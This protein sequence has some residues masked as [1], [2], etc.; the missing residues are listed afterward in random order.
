VTL[1]LVSF[2]T[3][4]FATVKAFENLSWL[5]L[6]VAAAAVFLTAAST[7][8]SSRKKATAKA[9]LTMQ[10]LE[11][12]RARMAYSIRESALPDAVAEQLFD[13]RAWTEIALPESN[14]ARRIGELEEVKLATVS[15]LG[16]AAA[17][18]E[19]KKLN[20]DE[21]DRILERRRAV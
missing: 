18:S 20:R 8:R 6:A 15:T 7:L 19:A 12:Q 11:A 10:E 4:V 2:A 3:A 16:S 1:L 17:E 21:L 5:A 9:P 13:E 14:L